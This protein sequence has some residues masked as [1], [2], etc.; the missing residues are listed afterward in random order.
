M[1][2]YVK[3]KYTL[4]VLFSMTLHVSIISCEPYLALEFALCYHTS[5]ISFTDSTS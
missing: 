5:T 3:I 1:E 2:V 4:N